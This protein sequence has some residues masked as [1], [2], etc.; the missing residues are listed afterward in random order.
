L[1]SFFFTLHVQSADSIY[2]PDDSGYTNVKSLGTKGD[3]ATDDTAAIKAAYVKKGGIYFPRLRSQSSEITRQR[4]GVCGRPL[5]QPVGLLRDAVFVRDKNFG[6]RRD[7]TKYL[8]LL[9]TSSGHVPSIETT[10][11]RVG[12]LHNWTNHR[13]Y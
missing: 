9:K 5:F 11:R 1:R 4:I 13:S 10:R 6:V 2:W 7:M 8:M 3:G 12:A